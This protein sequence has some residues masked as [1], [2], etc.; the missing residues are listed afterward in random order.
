V[1]ERNTAQRIFGAGQLSAGTIAPETRLDLSNEQRR[2]YRRL[3]EKRQGSTVGASADTLMGIRGLG[4]FA[5]IEYEAFDKNV[6]RFESGYSS[7]SWSG[8]LGVDY[9][10]TRWLAAGVAFTYS[11]LSGDYAQRGGEFDTQSVGG[12]IYATFFPLPR[13]FVDVVGGYERKNYTTDRVISYTNTFSGVNGLKTMNGIASGETDGDEYRTGVNIGYDFN[14][15][16]VTFGPRLGVNYRHTTID[17]FSERGKRAVFCETPLVQT[18]PLACGAVSGTGLELSY[19]RQHETSLTTVAGLFASVSLSTP[20]GVVVPQATF[21]YVHE[22]A[23]DQRVIR[24]TFVEDPARAKFRFQNDP[25]DRDH[26]H[27]GG[28]IV[29]VLPGGFT[30]F[31][32]YRALVGYK[33]HSS[34]TVTAGLRFAF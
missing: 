30:P 12:L 11:S 29:L 13:L 17:G 25:P 14:I 20:F 26:F 15:D 1:S 7:D 9:L 32:N 28:G 4:L 33:D 10:F 21:E 5:S 16:R 34:H 19:D 24:F 18:L 3:E 23:D 27:A 8:T 31:V 6:T 2:V 22:F